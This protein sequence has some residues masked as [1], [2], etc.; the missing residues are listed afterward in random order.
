MIL[1]VGLRA[2]LCVQRLVRAVVAVVAERCELLGGH[3][4]VIEGLAFRIA[5]G[6]EPRA[7]E[8]DVPRSGVRS[9]LEHLHIVDPE[10]S[11]ELNGKGGNSKI[12]TFLRSSGA[13][14][15]PDLGVRD[16]K[17][18]VEELIVLVCTCHDSFSF[19]IGISALW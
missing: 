19:A 3:A 15:D 14:V 6:T 11:V 8:L 2:L 9:L 4:D 5:L 17:S 7:G 18:I 10:T 16:D 12:L 13:L 1:F